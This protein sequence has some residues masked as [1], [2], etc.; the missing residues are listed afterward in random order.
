MKKLLFLSLFSI[1]F[2]SFALDNCKYHKFV[3]HAKK[4]LEL[5]PY[6]GVISEVSANVTFRGCADSLLINDIH[7]ARLTQTSINNESKR[8]NCVYSLN[9]ML[10]FCEN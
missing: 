7:V 10:I 3:D 9:S 5:V 8:S 4:K 6:P 2:Q 1:S